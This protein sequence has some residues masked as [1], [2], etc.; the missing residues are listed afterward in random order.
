VTEV[1]PHSLLSLD[2]VAQLCSLG[3]VKVDV[4]SGVCRRERKS[5][6]EEARKERKERKEERRLD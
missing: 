1:R 3:G 5:E 4:A 6:K 2:F